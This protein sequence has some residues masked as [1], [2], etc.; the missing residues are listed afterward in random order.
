MNN[1]IFIIVI[2]SVWVYVYVNDV[3]ILFIID[4]EWVEVRDCCLVNF[5]RFGLNSY[6][7]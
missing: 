6:F 2:Y 3:K 7:L 1:F 4:V 5:S